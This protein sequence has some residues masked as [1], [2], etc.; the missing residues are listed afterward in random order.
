[1][2]E[3]ATTQGQAIQQLSQLSKLSPV[4][5]RHYADQVIAKDVEKSP[6]MNR[7]LGQISRIRSALLR[8]RK[9]HAS[10]AVVRARDG[11]VQERIQ[12]QFIAN[13]GSVWGRYKNCRRLPALGQAARAR[14]AA[15]RARPR[16]I[17]PPAHAQPARAT[18][19]QGTRDR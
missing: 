4:A 3:K 5:I 16:G 12:R 17:H 6:R 10:R 1:M 13:P 11:K 8:A 7:V 9:K 19:G 15:S 2:A 14:P 18:P